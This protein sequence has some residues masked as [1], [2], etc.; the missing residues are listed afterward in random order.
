MG[1]GGVE[2]GGGEGDEGVCWEGEGVLVGRDVL[3]VLV[4]CWNVGI[5]CRAGPWGVRNFFWV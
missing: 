1:S 2:E 3:E 5:E 4:G